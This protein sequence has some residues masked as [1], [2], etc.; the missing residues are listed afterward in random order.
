MTAAGAFMQHAKEEVENESSTYGVNLEFQA[1]DNLLVNFD[2]TVST[3]QAPI[4]G[5][6]ALMRNTRAQMT[7]HKYGPGGG[8]SVTST[9]PLLSPD[10]WEVQKMSLAS[11]VVDDQVTQFRGDATYAFYGENSL[12][13]I[14]VGARIYRGNAGTGTGTS[15]ASLRDEPITNFGG[16]GPFPAEDDFLKR[17]GTP[18]ASPDATVCLV[19]VQ[20]SVVVE[21]RQ[22]HTEARVP[23]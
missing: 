15:I 23:S 6:N 22:C 7:Y 12:D 20:Q 1:T 8:P 17:L 9:S 4:I 18:R 10:F 13:S 3:T 16:S 14:Q 2:A 19:D 21:I 11:H 5:G